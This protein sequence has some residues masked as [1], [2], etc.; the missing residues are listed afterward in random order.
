MGTLSQILAGKE[1]PIQT[2]ADFQTAVQYFARK[3]GQW[4]FRGQG[5]ARWPLAPSLERLIR[6]GVR[7]DASRIERVFLTRFK[8]QAHHYLSTTPLENSTLEWLALMQHWGVPTRLLDFTLSPYLGLFFAIIDMSAEGTASAVWAIRYT[9][10]NAI[11][12]DD[13]HGSVIR[14]ILPGWAKGSEPLQLH[15]LFDASFAQRRD[16]EFVAPVQPFVMNERLAVQQGMFLCPFS[17]KLSF[18]EMFVI[19]EGFAATFDQKNDSLR[20][21]FAQKFVIAPGA[22]SEIL[23]ELHRMNISSAALFP[24]LHGFARYIKEL[25][26]ALGGVE[27]LQ[28][29]F[30]L[31]A[32]EDFGSSG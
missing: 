7:E 29:D 9:W 1:T 24:G 19:P 4:C 17:L 11:V 25:Y 28:K 5:D 6:K 23:R 12:S 21:D 2:W 32:I 18:E 30:E 3:R 31:G 27:A 22:R 26:E 16:L 8:R 13:L 20:T 15:R 14:E 10:L